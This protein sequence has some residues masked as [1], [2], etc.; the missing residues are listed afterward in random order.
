VN[1]I[2]AWILIVIFL[3]N[4]STGYAINQKELIEKVIPSGLH[5]SQIEKISG[6]IYWPSV[7]SAFEKSVRVP[8]VVVFFKYW[9]PDEYPELHLAIIALRS[10]S[11]LLITE[12]VI[13]SD[14]M[15]KWAITDDSGICFPK[16]MNGEPVIAVCTS[17]GLEGPFEVLTWQDGKLV[18][19]ISLKNGGRSTKVTFNKEGEMGFIIGGDCGYKHDSIVV[20]EVY[21]IRKGKVI[22]ASNQFHSIYK[23]L[24]DGAPNCDSR[25]TPMEKLPEICSL[26]L[27]YQGK[28]DEAINLLGYWMSQIVYG[29]GWSLGA[30]K[31]HEMKSDVYLVQ[32]NV[33]KAEEESISAISCVSCDDSFWEYKGQEQSKVPQDKVKYWVNHM[34]EYKKWEQGLLSSYHC[35]EPS[36]SD[37]NWG[38]FNLGLKCMK[39]NLYP[40]A[41]KYLTDAIPYARIRDKE[42]REMNGVQGQGMMDIIEDN[43]RVAQEAIKN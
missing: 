14:P 39:Y 43:I 8:V 40:N 25:D 13:N 5:P 41:I 33:N 27:A 3:G 38:L 12:R 19:L 31:L 15:F 29:R 30:S 35:P 22:W 18:P 21:L 37:R 9:T 24:I 20:P 11:P 42:Y 32:G 4:S 2:K 23:D 7:Y 36:E 34:D 6:T 17:G 28:Y 10:G 16:G 26:A 1:N